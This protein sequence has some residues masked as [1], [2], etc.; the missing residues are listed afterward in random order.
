MENKFWHAKTNEEVF[1][2]TSTQANGLTTEEAQARLARDGKNA[3]AEGKKRPL[4]L[5]FLDQFKDVMIIVLLVAAAVSAVISIVEGNYSELIDSGLIL[6]IV[7]VNAIIGLVQENKAEAALDALKNI[8]KPFAKVIRDGVLTKIKSEEIVV[9]DIVVLE[10]GDIVPADIRLFE[11]AS[12][13]VEEAALTGESVP[14]EKDASFIAKED[15]PLGDRANMCYSSGVVSYGR[16]QGV[17]V[18]VGMNTEVGKI[19]GMLNTQEKNDT[20]RH[21]QSISL[22]CRE[23]QE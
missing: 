17:V 18:A 1:E 11:S 23:A 3:L 15:A 22:R 2:A 21:T 16:G 14:S 7:V 13:K 5:K 10:A 8:N 6:L 4:V 9:G 12:L 19:A 20:P